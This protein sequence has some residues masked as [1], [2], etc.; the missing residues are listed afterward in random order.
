M[1]NSTLLS[2]LI[3]SVMIVGLGTFVALRRK[4]TKPSPSNG[5]TV[6]PDMQLGAV[7]TFRRTLPQLA[8]E[9][10]RVRR[11]NRPLTLLV[12]K[13][14]SD[15]LLLDLKRSL[16]AET[17]N[18]SVSSYNNIMQTIQLVFSLVGS[19]LSESLRESDI[20]TYDV[21]NN[22]YIILLPESDMTQAKQTVRRLKKLLFKRTAGHLVAGIAH[23]PSDGFIIED[24]VRRAVEK[25]SQKRNERIANDENERENTNW[26]N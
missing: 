6:S 22:Q 23:F 10:A 16:V 11:Y 13:I 21:A 3:P 1:L 5:R 4:R 19:V 25:C 7:S 20:A 8:N 17:G 26:T 14:E 18:G 24:L 2:F 15:Q 9:L 12:L